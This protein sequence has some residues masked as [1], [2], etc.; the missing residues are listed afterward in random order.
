M[1]P[2]M[3]SIFSAFGGGRS[4]EVG[5]GVGGRHIRATGARKAAPGCREGAKDKK[6]F[7]LLFPFY[8]TP[9]EPRAL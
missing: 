9:T 4:G 2:Q 3:G 7:K 5:T 8:F 1:P 6:V